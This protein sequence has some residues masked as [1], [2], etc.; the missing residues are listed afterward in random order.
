MKLGSK[1]PTTPL[2]F[3]NY[4][5]SHWFP[6]NTRLSLID[7]VHK[8]KIK[9]DT[10]YRKGLISYKRNFQHLIDI[11][12]SKKIDVILS[13]YCHFLYDEVKNDSIHI[14]YDQVIDE[15]NK[16]MKELAVKNGLKIIDNAKLIPLEKKYF[17][18]TVHFSHLG[19]IELAK[20]LSK[21]F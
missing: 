17:V 1:I 2:N 4:F 8:G 15:E 5:L 11:C 10:D 6:Y 21:A 14:L 13:T 16:I 12:K 18:D 19:M 7:L 9:E 20:N 3:I